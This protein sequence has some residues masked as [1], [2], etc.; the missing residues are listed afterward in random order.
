MSA[1]EKSK[2]NKPETADA[3]KKSIT[4]KIFNIQHFC[5]DDGPGIR[6]TVFLKGCPLRCA[7]CHN[8][9]GLSSETQLMFY[10]EKCVSCGKCAVLCPNKAHTVTEDGRH[11]L[12]RTKCTACGICAENCFYGAL[13]IAGREITAEE[14]VEEVMKDEPFYTDG[15]GVTLSGGEPLFQADFT[16]E[17]L[18]LCKQKGLHTCVETS[19]FAKREQFEKVLR[20]TDMLLFDIKETDGE[21]HKKFTGV[22]LEQIMDNLRLADSCDRVKTVLR[23][24]SVPGYNLRPEHFEAVAELAGGLKNVIEIHIEPYHPL[25]VEKYGNLGLDPPCKDK[26]FADKAELEKIREHMQLLTDVPIKIN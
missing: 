4:G 5:V 22:G 17:I 10:A 16:A 6:T 12:D 24:P 14:A 18:R 23:L 11:L 8:P 3:P 20:Y 9:E 25:G 13:E 19:G 2:Q 7:W 1:P 15:G 21:L 26:N